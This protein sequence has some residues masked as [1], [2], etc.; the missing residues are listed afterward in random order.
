[1]PF[2]HA[3]RARKLLLFSGLGSEEVARQEED[4][5][6][7][8]GQPAHEVGVPLGAEGDVDA[9]AVAL[10]DELALQ[11][12]ADAVEHLE[13]EGWSFDLVRVSEAAE[14]VDDGLVVG[15]DAAKDLAGD[16]AFGE[17]EVVGVDVGLAGEGDVVG[18]L[19]STFAEADADSLPEQAFGVGF[20]AE[21]V[22]LEDG[23]D[24]TGEASEEALGDGEGGFGVLGAFH[25]DAD[26]VLEFCGVLDEGG[27][28]AFG[29]RLTFG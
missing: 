18:F 22:G 3:P 9:D 11:V 20:G 28:D 21:H 1:M 2:F 10:A 25:V 6:G 16:H 7:A 29:E 4:V 13:L 8:F 24:G 12:A 15:G 14:F 17:L 23:A 26:E 5:G 19:V 27:D